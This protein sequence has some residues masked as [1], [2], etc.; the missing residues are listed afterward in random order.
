[1]SVSAIAWA[2]KIEIKPTE[3]LMLVALCDHVND[4][5]F[6]CWPSI[7][8]LQKKTGLSRPAVWKTIDKLIEKGLVERC[9]FNE[10]GRTIYQI[11]VGNDITQVG[12]E[13]TQ[14]QV[15]A[16]PRVGNEVTQG[17]GNEVTSK[18]SVY[19][20][21]YNR[22]SPAPPAR[23][24][25][26]A[27]LADFMEHPEP[28][29]SE[30]EPASIPAENSCPETAGPAQKQP[31]TPEE[32]GQW[33]IERCHRISRYRP[34]LDK[35]INPKSMTMFRQWIADGV[36][37]DDVNDAALAAEA[38]NGGMPATPVFYRGFVAELLLEKQR[39]KEN[40]VSFGDQ[41]G[42]MTKNWNNHYAKNERFGQRKLSAAERQLYLQREFERLH[43]DD[44]ADIFDI[45]EHCARIN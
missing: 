35:A 36:T 17:V 29:D 10:F 7:S 20:P 28:A 26:S 1:M 19:K 9:G 23:A 6:K 18:P 5:D 34:T 16:L 25:E 42:Q 45:T 30:P 38:K 3:K 13:V 41:P 40:P 14:G 32:W 2:W 11:N 44:G 31:T 27:F 43:P 33:F 8:H 21:S 12:N 37:L 4:E 39:A 24:R 15:T 22:K